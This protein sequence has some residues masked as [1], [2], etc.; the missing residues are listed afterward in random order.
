MF[1]TFTLFSQSV[2]YSPAYQNHPLS[3][4]THSNIANRLCFL[5]YAT[6]DLVGR[7]NR[8]SAKIIALRPSEGMRENP[9]LP[10]N[11]YS[12]EVITAYQYPCI[13]TVQIPFLYELR[14][15]IA[16]K[17]LLQNSKAVCRRN[18]RAEVG[19]SIM[20]KKSLGIS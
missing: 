1:V 10:N 4:S 2:R 20:A 8:G 6:I 19:D 5:A 9:Q 3:F 15:V 11:S 18:G 13:A 16:M 14:I 7:S 12:N 17:R